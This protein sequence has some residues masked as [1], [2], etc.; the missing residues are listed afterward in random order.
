MPVLY[1][2]A[3]LALNSE[4]LNVRGHGRSQPSKWAEVLW[5]VGCACHRELHDGH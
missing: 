4:M 3:S 2:P 5:S 1:L